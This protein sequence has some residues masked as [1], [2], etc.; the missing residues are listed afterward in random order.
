MRARHRR[1]GEGG[2][3]RD[4]DIDLHADILQLRLDDLPRPLEEVGIVEQQCDLEWLAAFGRYRPAGVIPGRFS[5]SL[6][7]AAS[8][9]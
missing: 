1:V 9:G 5:L 3:L 6:P 8:K 4:L 7:I 2:A